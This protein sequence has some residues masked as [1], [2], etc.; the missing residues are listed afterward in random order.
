VA[1]H[2]LGD[3]EL[4]AVLQVRRNSSGAEAVGADL[5]RDAGGEG[6]ALNHHVDVGFGQGARPVSLPWRSVGNR[7]AEHTQVPRVLRGFNKLT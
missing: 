7:G 1:G 6:S 2:L 3:F 4:A 5:R